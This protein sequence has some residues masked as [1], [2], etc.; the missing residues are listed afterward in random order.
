MQKMR[1]SISGN[2]RR[3]AWA[4]AAVMALATMGMQPVK[5]Q[6]FTVL[7]TFTGGA[8]GSE[9]LAGLVRDAAGNFY[10]TASAGGAD[11]APHCEF[12]CGAVFKLDKTSMIAAISST[13]CAFGCGTVFKLDKTGKLT[14]LH[15]FDGADGSSP[16]G[17]LVSDAKGNFYGTTYFGGT[18]D[19]GVVFKITP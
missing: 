2:T 19:A 13:A 17:G 12:G 16:Y 1:E 5:A 11:G 4:S 9:P 18:Y 10:G 14:V 7:Y 15:T 8:D 3:V 6:T